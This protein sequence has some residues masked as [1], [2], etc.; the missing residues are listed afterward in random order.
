MKH[1]GRFLVV[2]VIAMF[3]LPMGCSVWMGRQDSSEL[4]G[5]VSFFQENLQLLRDTDDQDFEDLA[6]AVAGLTT[7][8]DYANKPT[9]DMIEVPAG[10]TVAT[11]Y[12]CGATNVAENDD[13]GAVVYG[14]V[15][16]N[17]PKEIICDAAG[18][19]GTNAVVLYPD[20]G[21]AATGG[22][23]VDT[24]SVTTNHWRTT[25]TASK[26]GGD[27]DYIDT[28]SF[29]PLNLGWIGV[30]IYEADGTTA[31]EADEVTVFIA[32]TRE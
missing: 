26:S 9:S 17:G 19:I 1:L 8:G 24:W 30:D 21:A 23:W 14:Y 5:D 7:A 32:F 15:N 2:S 31:G 22:L 11:I 27:S 12:A 18:T 28:L 25:V 6:A 20:D 3:V 10:A 16:L 29:D 4:A 13:F